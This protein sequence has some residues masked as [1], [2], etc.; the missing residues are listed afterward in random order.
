MRLAELVKAL[1]R[2]GSVSGGDPDITHITSDSRQV[3]PGALFVACPG[4][5][6]DGHRFIPNAIERGAAAIVGQAAPGQVAGLPYVQVPD[7]REA[8][9]YLCAG[10]YGFPA[11]RLVMLGVT[12]TDGKTTTCNLIHNLLTAAG[13][14][15]GMITTVNAVIGGQT[16]DTGLHTT[17][18]DAPDVQKYLALMVEAG[19]T[20]CVLETTSHG[21]AQHRADACEFDIGVITN[22]THEH[23]DFHG[24]FEAYRAAKARLFEMVAASTR[25]GIPKTAVLNADDPSYEF[26]REIRADAE[27]S[28][29]MATCALVS[30]LEVAHKP[31]I[32]RFVAVTPVGRIPLATYLVGEHNV[33]NVLAAVSVGLALRLPVKAIQ[34]GVQALKSVPGR[35]ERIDEGQSFTA[36]VDFCHTPNALERVLQTARRMTKGQVIVVFGSAGLRDVDKRGMMG[37]VAGRWAD[38]IVITA[39]DPRT[40]SLDDIM[41]AIAEGVAAEGRSE[42][43]DFWR[44]GDRAEAIL[45]AVKLARTGDVV[46]ACGKGHE[47]SMCFGTV[48]YPWDDR[49][50]MRTALRSAQ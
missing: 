21:L 7:A 49:R 5:S 1:P 20:H 42:G 11:R 36:I 3:T 29:G 39:E 40:E 47:Q 2:G 16:Y 24:S 41:A 48:E 4:V 23:L 38:K 9:A 26:L 13:L 32:T 10:W 14:S 19:Q 37:H 35:W 18:P 22:I 17:T 28:Y 44:V 30:T 50:A 43:Q 15:A 25:K 46:L 45:F 33:M 8:L 6:V 31:D 12:G 34:R 27:L